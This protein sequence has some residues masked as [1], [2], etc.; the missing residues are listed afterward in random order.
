MTEYIER[1]TVVDAITGVYIST[2]G[3]KTRQRVWKAR[4]A[5]EQL[6]AAD[7][8][9]VRHGHWI[10]YRIPHI[11]C[12]SECDYGLHPLDKDY[13][14]CPMCGTKMEGEGGDA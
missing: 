8:A 2:A 11:I 1:K 12:C 3:Y 5:V 14:Y 10:E 7:V 6:P 13:R 4:E 9:P